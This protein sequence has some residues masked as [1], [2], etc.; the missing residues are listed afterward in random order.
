MDNLLRRELNP[1]NRQQL[2]PI[3]RKRD[4]F[5]N[6]KH[7]VLHYLVNYLA[8]QC[9]ENLWLP[10]IKVDNFSIPRDP[11]TGVVTLTADNMDI[12][13]ICCAEPSQY[14]NNEDI[15]FI[16]C[17]QPEHDLFLKSY[18][19]FNIGKT[20]LSTSERDEFTDR[21]YRICTD[22]I[23]LGIKLGILGELT[24]D[25]T[26]AR[27]GW[28]PLKNRIQE[29]LDFYFSNELISSLLENCFAR[30]RRLFTPDRKDREN[31]FA[32]YKDHFLEASYPKTHKSERRKY[33]ITKLRRRLK[34]LTNKSINKQFKN[35]T[36]NFT[37][38]TIL[39]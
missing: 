5:I 35:S 28:V 25:E 8:C 30:L 32:N 7:F 13:A 14:N 22:V 12:W 31:T 6:E 38:T 4:Y 20:K 2:Q 36:S 9:P 18:I 37:Y 39:I 1:N 15:Y 3:I 17:Q 21:Y 16:N 34:A 29:I 33:D 23:S 26:F 27:R 19:R 11:D 24:I 10:F